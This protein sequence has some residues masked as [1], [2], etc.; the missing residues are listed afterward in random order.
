MDSFEALQSKCPK[1]SK[2]LFLIGLLLVLRKVIALIK[3][4]HILFLRRRKNLQ[5]RY[6]R[7]SWAFIT[8]SSEGKAFIM[9]RYRQS[10]GIFIGQGGI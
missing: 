3:K 5:Q 6:G 1:T 4:F 7:G 9:L 10:S 2:I 8:G